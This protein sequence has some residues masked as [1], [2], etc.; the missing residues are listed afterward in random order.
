MNPKRQKKIEIAHKMLIGTVTEKYVNPPKTW[1]KLLV[2]P[3]LGDDEIVT[4]HKAHCINYHTRIKVGD[5]IKLETEYIDDSLA[6]KK[7]FNMRSSGSIEIESRGTPTKKEE[8][9]MEER[10]E[11]RS[12][13]GLPTDIS[14]SSGD[15]KLDEFAEEHTEDEYNRLIDENTGGTSETK[16]TNTSLVIPRNT[17]LMR[18]IASIAEIKKAWKEYQIFTTEILDK[19]DY[20]LVNGKQTKKKSAFRKYA[21]FFGI[22]CI[23]KNEKRVDLPDGSF[24]FEIIASAYPANDPARTQDGDGSCHSTEKKFSK[25]GKL[26]KRFYHDTR[27]T[28]ITRAK[29]RA[30]SELIAAG[31]VSAEEMR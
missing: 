27:A 25:D 14:L 8:P 19:S 2:K 1:M 29:N 9:S 5:V 20:A 6:G 3:E 26:N 10:M 18:P 24:V 13:A 31:E 16:T 11:N 30:I 28:A 22:S 15:G 23:V 21:T 12:D 4:F 17:S 7:V